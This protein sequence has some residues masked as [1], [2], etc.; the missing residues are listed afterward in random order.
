MNKKASIVKYLLGAKSRRSSLQLLITLAILCWCSAARAQFQTETWLGSATGTA[1][2]TNKAAW[3]A[4]GVSSN[5]DALIFGSQAQALALP[6]FTNSA[7]NFPTTVIKTGAGGY[8]NQFGIYSIT[9]NTNGINVSGNALQITNGISDNYGQNSESIP[10]TLGVSQTFQNNSTLGNTTP[11]SGITT[12]NNFTNTE[13]GTIALFTNT[14]TLGGSAPLFVSGAISAGTNGAGYVIVTDQGTANGVAPISGGFVRLSAANFFGTNLVVNTN[15]FIGAG[16]YNGTTNY[17][18]NLFVDVGVYTNYFTVTNISNPTNGAYTTGPLLYFP[19]VQDAVS[20]NANAILQ[21][22]I[23]TAIPTGAHVGNLYVE[24]ELDLNGYSLTVNGLEDAGDNL[25]VI[26]N[27]AAGNNGNYV[28]TIG[29]ANSNSVYSGTIQ[30]TSGSVGVTKTGYGTNYFT[31]G[32]GY[33]GPTLINQGTLALSGSGTLGANSSTLTIASGAI[34]D[35]SGISSGY[36]PSTQAGVTVAAGTPTKPYTN[37]LGSYDTNL[38]SAFIT[39]TISNYFLTYRTNTDLATYTNVLIIS[40]Q[41]ANTFSSNTIVSII[42]DDVVGD[43][44]VIGGGAISPITSVS[45][46]IATWNISG[47]LNIDNSG[48]LGNNRVNFLLNNVTTTGGGT[49]DLIAV[50]GKLHI[51]DE[52]DFVITPLSG[53]LAAGTYTLMTSSGYTGTGY[54]NGHTAFLNPVLERGLQ[55][56]TVQANG[57]NIQF[58]SLGGAAAPGSVIWSATNAAKANWDVALSQNWITNGPSLNAQGNNRDYFYPLDNVSFDDRG[59]GAVTLPVVVAPS[60]ITFNNIKTNYTFTLSPSTF[61]AGPGGI[62]LNGSGSVTLQNPNSFTGDITVNAGTL[63]LGYYGSASPQ[64]VIYNGVPAGSLHLGG[65]TINQNAQSATT[66]LAPF[67]NLYITPGASAI[68]QTTRTAS[69]S[70]RYSIS[71]NVVR[72]VGGVLNIVP[73]NSNGQGL[74]FW[75]TNSPDGTNDYGVN[76]ILGGYATESAADWI[77]ATIGNIAVSYANYQGDNNPAD[78]GS[79]SNVLLGV[80]SLTPTVINIASSVT[81]NSIRLT[82]SGPVV[83]NISNGKHLTVSSGGI[84]I[85]V[86]GLY[87]SAING[88]TVLGNPGQDLIIHNANTVGGSFTIGSVIADN[89]GATGLTAA[90]GGVTVLT[91]NN[92]YTGPTYIENGYAG[93][94]PGV[95]Q[96]GNNSTSGTI[97]SSSAV[98]DNGNLAFNRSDSIAVNGVISGFGGLTKLSAGALTLTANSTLSGQ[99]TISAGTLQLGNGGAAGSFSN[100]VGVLDNATLVFDNNNTVSYPKPISGYGGVVQFGSGN[101]VIATNEIYTGNTTVS[102]GT[103]TLTASG[104]ISN[105]AVIT[106]MSGALLDVSAAGGL[107]LRSSP[108]AEVLQGNGTINGQVTTTNGTTLDVLPGVSGFGTLTFNNA[109]NLTGGSFKFDVSNTGSDLINVGG[110][111]AETSGNIVIN[112][113]GTLNP[114]VYKLIQ[115]TGTPTLTVGLVSTLG[116]AGVVQNG[117]VAVLTNDTTSSLSLMVYPGTITPLTWSGGNNNNAWDS[118]TPNWNS[119]ALDYANPDY[120]T[121]DDTGSAAPAVNITIAV[122]A[123]GITNN[124]NANNYVF[125]TSASGKITGGAELVQ[126]GSSLLTL[127][128]LNDYLGGTIIGNGTVQLGNNTSAAQDGMVGGNRCHRPERHLGFQQFRNGNNQRLH[129][130]HGSTGA[131]WRRET[132]FGRQ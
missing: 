87:F 3:S 121:F 65:G 10:L 11:L 7:N 132:D 125:G 82:N 101:L 78:W 64:Y 36:Y 99:V 26:D 29:N 4:Q 13:S 90:G 50:G 49:N 119:G 109:L 107:T 102:N 97:A 92:T 39:T 89:G 61:I 31:G 129:Q 67:Q 75:N 56:D 51:G 33:S 79:T 37:F 44:N 46:G 24:G 45:P 52:L 84:L 68:T 53:T 111:L 114:G 58:T 23:A 96:I 105:T 21:L 123:T 100:T 80:T 18:T 59:Y 60:S 118:I 83:I 25:G 88:G 130:R 42:N 9:F 35:V 131:G 86:A 85:P 91:G 20:V 8:T 57:N 69:E 22:G 55:G 71:N 117:D 43:F 28:L 74:Y 115:E 14:L 2:W 72:S 94:A 70:A 6:L 30:N 5:G 19:L 66:P 47:N 106:V 16:T 108:P 77:T 93:A 32:N 73:S 34:L 17:Y 95:L 120:A 128:T 113:T 126:N 104:S 62:T 15:I 12:T 27:L 81:N 54:N 40:N 76:G 103:L 41:L 98:I 124:A 116:L 48:L 127:Q 112:K 1:T 63:N 122:S 110:A 38:G